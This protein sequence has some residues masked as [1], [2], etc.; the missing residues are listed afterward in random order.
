MSDCVS[1]TTSEGAVQEYIHI[2]GA[3]VHNLQNLDLDIPE[4][5]WSW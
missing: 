1:E 2:R 4:I 3:R 5:E